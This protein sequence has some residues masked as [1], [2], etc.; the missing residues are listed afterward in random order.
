MST[1][2]EIM[3]AKNGMKVVAINDVDEVTE[4]DFLI[5]KEGLS[6]ETHTIPFDDPQVIP[7]DG[8]IFVATKAKDHLREGDLV[9]VID[10]ITII[11][12]NKSYPYMIRFLHNQEIVYIIHN[13]F[14]NTKTTLA[15]FDRVI[16]EQ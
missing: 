6:I 10:C 9:Q 8:S 16:E 14:M 4:G 1:K 13:D 11:K 15:A 12:D 2:Q 3:V 7:E 5:V